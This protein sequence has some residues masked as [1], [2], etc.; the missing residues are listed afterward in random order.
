MKSRKLEAAK[1]VTRPCFAASCFRGCLWASL[2]AALVACHPAV[3]PATANRPGSS[4]QQQIDTL[5]GAP[6]LAHG[7]WGVLVKSLRTGAVLYAHDENKLLLP[8]SNMKIL[9]TAVAASRLGWQYTYET[10]VVAAGESTGGILHGDLVV[11]G[12]GD[13]SMTSAGPDSTFSRWA[14]RLRT[15]G[16][17]RIDGRIIGDDH[18]FIDDRLGFGWSWTD[19]AED[20]SAGVS[21]LQVDEDVVRVTLTPGRT[22][23]AIA[24]VSASPAYTA[25]NNSVVTGAAD[26]TPTVESRRLGDTK[27]VYLRGSVPLGGAPVVVALAAERPTTFFVTRLRA[28]LIAQGIDVAGPAIDLDDI[29]EPVPTRRTLLFAHQS[30]PLGVLATRLMKVSQNLYAEAFLKT[31]G[32]EN[33]NP[34]WDGGRA[35]LRETLSQWG[36]DSSDVVVA[37]GSGLSRYDFVTP[38]AVVAVLAHVYGDPTLKEPFMAT[39]PIA[40]RDGSL[41]QRM[42]GTAAEG[43]VLAKTGSM[44]RVRAVSGYATTA[45]GEPLAFSIIANNF[46][47]APE[48]ITSTADAIMVKL[49]ELH[50]R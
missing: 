11:V 40:G 32:A 21:A 30:A 14:S 23:G 9:T 16:L 27:P 38:A 43:N 48:A 31:L 10:D 2:A 13:P 37:D 47:V 50:A 49:A 41:A 29:V 17:H 24:A 19:L 28:A 34:T 35:A 12:S 5:I 22:P 46:D 33:G 45:D 1:K 3:P 6:E 44:T 7:Y 25:L 15:A 39:L 18:R 42:K 4:L 8:A 26:S 20:Y 36:I